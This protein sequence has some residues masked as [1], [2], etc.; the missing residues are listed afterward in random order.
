[1]NK[2]VLPSLVLSIL[3]YS[4]SQSSSDI[5][6]SDTEQIERIETVELTE[7]VVTPEFTSFGTIAYIDKAD[8][9]SMLEGIVERIPVEEGDHVEVGDLLAVIDKQQLEIQRSEAEAEIVSAEAAVELAK[10][11]LQDGEKNIEAQFISIRNAEAEIAQLQRE[12]EQISRTYENKQQLFEIEG[13]TAEEMESLK[14]RL[15]STETK[16][17]T[18][19]G[20]LAIQQ[21]GFRDIDIRNAGHKIPADPLERKQLLIHLNTRTLQT[22][23]EVAQAGLNAARSNLKSINLLISRS[24]IRAPIAGIVA[25]KNVYLGEKAS[26]DEPLFTIFSEKRLVVQSEVTEQAVDSIQPGQH[27]KIRT[28]FS[29]RE[30]SGSVYFIAPY[31]NPESRTT[32]VKIS[33]D[34]P[35]GLRPGM[36]VRFTIETGVPE[37]ALTV[38]KSALLEEGETSYLFLVRRS[39]LFKTEVRVGEERENSVIIQ[40]GVRQGDIVARHARRRFSDGMKVTVPE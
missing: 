1:M 25:Q 29:E 40:S 8:I 35:V 27:T 34:D 19:K 2:F 13:V 3:L 9:S 7:E 39:R 15:R 37:K 36:F 33:I 30:Y 32:A 26:P 5:E 38:P 6:A 18:A 31:Q 28:D 24:R 14:T 10:S 21:I 23:L 17:F 11:Q 12:L 16:L 4:C 22:K 20:E